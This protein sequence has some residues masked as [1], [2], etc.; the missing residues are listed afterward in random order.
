VVSGF[1]RTIILATNL[2]A[3]MLFIASSRSE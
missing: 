1:R 2:V 3:A